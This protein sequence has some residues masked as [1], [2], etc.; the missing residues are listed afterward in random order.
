MGCAKC[1]NKIIHGHGLCQKCYNKEHNK[2][3]R[4]KTNKQ[5]RERAYI[6]TS[7]KPMDENKKC[8]LFLGI[9]IAENILS[10]TFKNVKRMPNNTP[11]YDFICDNTNTEDENMETE[12]EWKERTKHRV[13]KGK[14]NLVAEFEEKNK[15]RINKAVKLMKYHSSSNLEVMRE[16]KLAL[17]VVRRIRKQR[18]E[19]VDHPF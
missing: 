16:C 19:K 18:V 6:T 12:T 8:A 2:S 3:H 14:R 5:H 4:N 7:R 1:E 15:D 13:T 9:H 10:K 17:H 11:W